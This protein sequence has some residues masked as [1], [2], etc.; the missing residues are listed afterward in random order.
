[1]IEPYDHGLLT[2]GDGH[3][4]YWE[5]SGAPHGTPAVVLHGGP[6]S[7]SAPS[8]RRL[9]DPERFRI[10]QFD[11]RGCGRS[12]PHASAPGVDL[13]TNTTHHLIAD[14]ERLRQHL[15]VD[16]W[17][18][19]GGSWGSTLALAYAERHPDAVSA[20]VLFSVATTTRRDVA[21]L[22]RDVGRLFPAEWERFRAGVP[23]AERD[24]DLAAAYN[25]LL[26]DPDPAI[27]EQAAR[28]WCRWEAAHVRTRPGEPPDPRYDD[29]AFR[30][31]FAR[32]VT[33]Y[34]SH[35][36][37]L[38]DGE[39]ERGAERLAG[40]P[41]ALVHGRLDLSS[42]LDVPWRLAQRWPG[43]ELVIVDE[44]HGGGPAM[45]RAIA[46]AIERCYESIA[47]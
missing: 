6:G 19:A 27:H 11:Q 39:L 35:A 18:V 24:G 36:A 43:S 8:R 9:F 26:L 17:L 1:V 22:T 40:I 23:A 12:R 16:R 47:S 25:R 21:W 5:T 37:W 31:A 10:V 14:I 15:G 30:L 29:P 4:L 44:G 13:S 20:L 45:T 41:G 38:E 3:E 32:L 33:H 42:P 2:V 7:G 28:D 46:G 34:W